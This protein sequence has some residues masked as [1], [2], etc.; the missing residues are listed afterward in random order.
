VSTMLLPPP[1][2]A[3]LERRSPS[4]QKGGTLLAVDV[5]DVKTH[6]RRRSSPDGY[7]PDSCRACGASRLHLHDYTERQVLSDEDVT[8]VVVVRYLCV[9]CAATWRVLPGFLPR[10]LRRR[11]ATVEATTLGPPPLPSAPR[12]PARTRARWRH[13]LGCALGEA[14]RAL[15]DTSGLGLAVRSSG[16]RRALVVVVAAMVSAAPGRRLAVV[17]ATLH[18]ALP[19][20]RLM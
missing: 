12:I 16:D 20:V 18:G 7:R 17:A 10:Y 2:P 5:M 4:T 8:L 14:L 19:G 13:R 3:C 15:E 11:W 9:A 6:E 1:P